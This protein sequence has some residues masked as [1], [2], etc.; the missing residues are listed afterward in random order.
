MA[1]GLPHP[2]PPGLRSGRRHPLPQCGR[3][4]LRRPP[5]G[6]SPALRE[7]GDPARRAGWVRVGC[8]DFIYREP[9]TCSNAQQECSSAPP[10]RDRCRAAH[11]VGAERPAFEAIQI[12]AAASD[13]IL[14]RRFRVH[15]TPTDRRAGR[16]SARRECRGSAPNGL[17]R[18]PRLEG[19]PFLEQRR[20][21]EYSR[22]GR[23][24]ATRSGSRIDTH[25][26]SATRWGASLSRDAG[27]GL[28]R[29]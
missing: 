15:Q 19:N 17:A 16:R 1:A 8:R 23:D 27:E 2:P 21:R 28:T 20:S 18:N 7:R 10:L 26:P 6:P 9:L 22:G 24:D 25:L 4:A 13:R 14:C 5:S 11:V 3:G 29:R 12:S